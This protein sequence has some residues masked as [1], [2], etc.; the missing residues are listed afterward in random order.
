MTYLLRYIRE[1]PGY[2]RDDAPTI[3][4]LSATV[5]GSELLTMFPECQVIKHNAPRFPVTT[6]YLK[7][8]AGEIM[9]E[10][11]RIPVT[12]SR[13]VTCCREHGEN[14]GDILVFASGQ[15]T[16]DRLVEMCEQEPDCEGCV[17]LRCYGQL[18][19][20]ELD[21]VTESVPMSLES[22]KAWQKKHELTELDMQEMGLDYIINQ[23]MSAKRKIVCGTN[24]L[25]SSVTV[26]GSE[27]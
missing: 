22:V 6:H 26:N 24:V 15:G 9:N 13:I 5:D 12:M 19:S 2:K 27:Y 7:S 18:S 14:P 17:A 23:M 11:S 1:L 3:S 21:L 8:S 16:V 4:F 10:K 25:E 20:A